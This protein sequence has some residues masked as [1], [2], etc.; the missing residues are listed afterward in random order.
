MFYIGLEFRSK[1]IGHIERFMAKTERIHQELGEC[2]LGVPKTSGASIGM[3][4]IDMQSDRYLQR[5][6]LQE[7]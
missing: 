2:M 6:Y 3:R 7:K 1:K 4:G 5:K